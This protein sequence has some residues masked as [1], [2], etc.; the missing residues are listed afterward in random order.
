MK[1]IETNKGENMKK[2]CGSCVYLEK[3]PGHAN[4]TGYYGWC[5]CPLPVW[6]AAG[7]GCLV[8]KR[9]YKGD[10]PAWRP[11]DD[12]PYLPGDEVPF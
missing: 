8:P 10:C 7:R 2:R 6:A 5:K 9:S 11:E 1:R 4:Y 3:P 12:V